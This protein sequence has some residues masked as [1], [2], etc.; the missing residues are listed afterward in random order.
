MGVDMP[1]E[2]GLD[3]AIPPIG[4]QDTDRESPPQVRRQQGA[5]QEETA[6]AGHTLQ[7]AARREY[8]DP[9]RRHRLRPVSTV[10][11]RS[12]GVARGGLRY[13]PAGEGS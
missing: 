6:A 10:R 2:T 13:S 3:T 12:D 9:H 5:N 1:E 4:W 8:R 11:S 7:E